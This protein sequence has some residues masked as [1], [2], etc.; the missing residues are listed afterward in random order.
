[1]AG[2]RRPPGLRGRGA[3]KTMPGVR[4]AHSGHP[5]NRSCSEVIRLG[6]RR[7]A[8]WPRAMRDAVPRVLH[9]VLDVLPRRLAAILEAV[10]LAP[11]VGLDLVP[12]APPKSIGRLEAV[13]ITGLIKLVTPI[14]PRI[15]ARREIGAPIQVLIHP[16]GAS[17]RRRVEIVTI[18]H[19][20]S[21]KSA[22]GGLAKRRKLRAA[23]RA[24]QAACTRHGS[25][26][27]GPRSL[28]L[29]L[30]NEETAPT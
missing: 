23:R 8:H 26:S 28:P 15:R 1:D 11:Q 16:V 21:M 6:R 20:S 30:P 22:A 24:A 29:G 2:D 5:R 3:Y 4:S 13:A 9:R 27:T 7:G 17:R 14:A 10:P 25:D 18:C 19:E 12:L